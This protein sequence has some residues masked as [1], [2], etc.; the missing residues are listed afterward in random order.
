MGHVANGENDHADDGQRHPDRKQKRLGD[1]ER[2]KLGKEYAACDECAMAG[3][4][5][6]NGSDGMTM[7]DVR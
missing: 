2:A 6:G 3:S 7:C 1:V 5:L 4:V